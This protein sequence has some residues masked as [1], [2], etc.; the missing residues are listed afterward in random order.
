MNSDFSTELTEY[1]DF[2]LY[3]KSINVYN[4]I[5]SIHLCKIKHFKAISHMLC[6][7]VSHDCFEMNIVTQFDIMVHIEILTTKPL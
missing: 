7:L 4:K 2:S 3:N 6:T 5:P 1:F